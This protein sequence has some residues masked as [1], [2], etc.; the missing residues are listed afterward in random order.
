MEFKIRDDFT[1]K[2][3]DRPDLDPQRKSKDLT[4]YNSDQLSQAVS[5][6]LNLI[7]KIDTSEKPI[8]ISYSRLS[9]LT[10][11]FSL[12]VIKSKKDTAIV[13]NDEILELDNDLDLFSFF[14]IAGPR[15][16]FKG[17]GIV[18]KAEEV[19]SHRF[20][21]D[22]TSTMD[23]VEAW[24]D[25]E[26]LTFELISTSG[27]I[28]ESSIIAAMNNYV[29][30]DDYCVLN[31]SFNHVGVHT[32]IIYPSLFKAKAIAVADNVRQWNIVCEDATHVHMGYQMIQEKFKLP[33]KLR[34]LSTGGYHFSLDCLNYVYSHSD[35]ERIVDCYG[36]VFC[37]PPLAIRDLNKE[38][39]LGLQPFKWVNSLV[40]PT[41]NHGTMHI[42]SD[43]ELFSKTF[44]AFGDGKSIA[45]QDIVEKVDDDIFYLYGS[46]ETYIRVS[47]TRITTTELQRMLDSV[48]PN[49]VIE[50][51]IKEGTKFPKLIADSLSKEKL[52][53]FI[54]DNK[55]EADIEYTIYQ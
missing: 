22:A 13:I 9:F 19:P 6:F 17:S 33:K 36:T 52:D 5:Y 26:K 2:S 48:I 49:T 46:T 8:G 32:L 23:A 38:N 10:I 50:F 37:P 54:I 45:T 12:A 43:Q 40:F 14:F 39:S 41:M 3:L 27:L 51:T 42:N 21:I 53:K 15:S 44:F 25:R 16:G 24:T 55:V 29:Y 47:D 7:N 30:D 18:S 28:E 34:T 11:A 4:T 35:I 20:Y 1:I 31:R